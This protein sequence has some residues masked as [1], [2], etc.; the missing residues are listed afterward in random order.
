MAGLRLLC[1][2]GVAPAPRICLCVPR[3]LAKSVVRNTSVCA[4]PP[5]LRLCVC[6]V[7]CLSLL[8][9]TRGNVPAHCACV[10]VPRARDESFVRDSW[11]VP[12]PCSCVSVCAL[13]E[14]IVRDSWGC[15][16]PL[17]VRV[18]VCLVPWLSLLCETRGDVP[19]HVFVRFV[20][21][22]VVLCETRGMCLPTCACV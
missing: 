10:C 2:T 5:W 14:S 7:P 19:A 17:F 20:T 18:C 6:L 21:G 3:A 13:A 9:E 4:C 11:H 1:E 22:W 12:A 15:A 16:C 8:C